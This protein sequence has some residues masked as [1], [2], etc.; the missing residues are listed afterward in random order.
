M[1]NNLRYLYEWVNEMG[2]NGRADSPTANY[3]EH[4]FGHA[5][6]HLSEAFFVLNIL[7]FFMHQ[8]FELVDGLYGQARAEFSAR[9]EYWNG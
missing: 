5:K 7:A 3:M 8:I 6:Q 9:T 2:L 4:N 1:E